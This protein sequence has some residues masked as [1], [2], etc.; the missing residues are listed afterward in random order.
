[1]SDLTLALGA[2]A[3]FMAGFIF[4]MLYAWYHCIKTI[5]ESYASKGTGHD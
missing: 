2:A 3:I 1:M 5:K 4:G